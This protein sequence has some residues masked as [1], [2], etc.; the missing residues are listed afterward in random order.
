MDRTSEAPSDP[1]ASVA[2]SPPDK[3]GPSSRRIVVDPATLQKKHESE[4]TV[5]N[6]HPGEEVKIDRAD[7]IRSEDLDAWFGPPSRTVSR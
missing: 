5:F 6:Y 1:D 7:K 3:A 4:A 2:P